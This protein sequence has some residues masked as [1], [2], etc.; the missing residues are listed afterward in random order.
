MRD[1]YQSTGFVA[2]VWSS[3]GQEENPWIQI[4]QASVHSA[5]ITGT[6][7]AKWVLLDRNHVQS[8][9]HHFNLWSRLPPY[10]FLFFS[11]I[12]VQ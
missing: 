9:S 12:V 4:I 10:L 6:W 1:D 11:A 7:I 3:Q 8:K 2:L 5:C